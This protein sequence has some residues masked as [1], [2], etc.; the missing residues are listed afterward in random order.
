MGSYDRLW[1]SAGERERRLSDR[2]MSP[3]GFWQRDQL[4]EGLLTT[5]RRRRQTH[6]A[7]IG[8]NRTPRRIAWGAHFTV[9]RRRRNRADASPSPASSPIEVRLEAIDLDRPAQPA[10]L[11]EKI[12]SD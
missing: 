3:A 2:Q 1:P 6:E 12:I 7:D 5:R 10:R 11:A 8:F 9:P 4:R